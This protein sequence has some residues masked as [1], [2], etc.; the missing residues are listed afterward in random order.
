MPALDLALVHRVIGLATGVPHALLLE[1]I[2]QI[3]RN[4][5]WPVVGEQPRPAIW[6]DVIESEA[7]NAS[8]SVSVTSAALIVVQSFQATM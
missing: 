5:R 1:P 7:R 4:V 8:P 3:A 6:L 2:G